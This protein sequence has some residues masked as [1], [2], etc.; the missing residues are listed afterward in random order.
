MTLLEK[1]KNSTISTLFTLYKEGLFYK[2]YNEDAMVFV[3]RVK[4]YKVSAKFVKSVGAEVLSLG[5]P[6]SSIGRENLSL[7]EIAKTIDAT[8]YKEETE[9]IVFMLHEHIKQNLEEFRNT[10]LATRPSRDK[11]EIAYDDSLS[12]QLIKL[13]QEFD[14]ANNTPMQGMS[15][16]QDLKMHIKNI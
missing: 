12:K 15:F 14:L 16:I 7:I 10:L 9:R 2:C 5:F 4:K 1:V 3:Q 8:S 11:E 13:I 6:A